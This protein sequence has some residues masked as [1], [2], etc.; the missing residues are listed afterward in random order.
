MRS[1]AEGLGSDA[2]QSMILIRSAL[3][4]WDWWSDARLQ[5]GGWRVGIWP[6]RRR[7]RTCP[8]NRHAASKHAQDSSI[9]SLS[10]VPDVSR[11][12]KVFV[13]DLCTLSRRKGPMHGATPDSLDPTQRFPTLSYPSYA[14]RLTHAPPPPPPRGSTGLEHRALRPRRD[15]VP[16]RAASLLYTRLALPAYATRRALVRRAHC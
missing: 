6:Q 2:A 4:A 13:A 3:Y 9:T 15:I 8:Q 16:T 10:R 5:R 11:Y 14:D 7:P 1:A 12:L